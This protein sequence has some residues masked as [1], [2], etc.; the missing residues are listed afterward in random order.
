LCFAPA[1]RRETVTDLEDPRLDDYRNL[2]DATL[3]G[4]R[5]RFIVEGRGTLRVLLSRSHFRPDSILLNER[6]FAA[7][8]A[9][10]AEF[11]PDC[12]IYVGGQPLLDRVVGFPIHRG[13]LAACARDEVQD[14]LDLARR[15]KGQEAAPRIIV[16]EGLTN[17]DNVGLIFRNAMAL[18]ARAVLLCP[19]TC[20][21]LYRKAIRTSM[22]G[23]LCVPFARA[24]N[25]PALLFGLRELE[26]EVLAFD[27]GEPGVEIQSL[28]APRLGATALLFGTEGPGL[29]AQAL[30]A[31][32]RRVRIAME[33][34]VDSLNV[35]VSAGIALSLL[36][37][38]EVGS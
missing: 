5:G 1:M 21:P 9:D 36:R 18:G 4:A 16:L 33:E 32:D 14:P 11:E 25:L 28:D 38:G 15:V 37:R 20:D 17:L 35:A 31:A 30:A 10:L 2:K 3:A 12:P 26:F 22:G 27:P 13:C 29:S 23:S 6:S 34:G 19:R 7:L 8:E 24:E